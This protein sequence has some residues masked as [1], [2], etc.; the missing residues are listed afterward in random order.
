MSFCDLQ[1]FDTRINLASIEIGTIHHTDCKLAESWTISPGIP[2]T[3]NGPSCPNKQKLIFLLDPLKFVA[4]AQHKGFHVDLTLT[5][6]LERRLRCIG[7]TR[8]LWS[9]PPALTRGGIVSAFDQC[10]R[11]QIVNFSIQSVYLIWIDI[12]AEQCTL[13]CYSPEHREYIIKCI[14]A[15]FLQLMALTNL[16]R[17]KMA[18]TQSWQQTLQ[19][20]QRSLL[21]ALSPTSIL[22]HNAALF[23]LQSNQKWRELWGIKP[24]VEFYPCS[25]CYKVQQQS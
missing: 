2:N 9:G 17:R 15:I 5:H 10:R 23:E 24:T 25:K 16:H 3:C 20:R 19:W 6:A 13:P 14:Q 12:D 4:A 8:P 22:K 11:E 18:S 7:T 1:A 21:I